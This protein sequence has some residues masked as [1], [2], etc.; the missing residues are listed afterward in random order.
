MLQLGPHNS[1]IRFRG[2]IKVMRGAYYSEFR[3]E[4]KRMAQMRVE[5][6]KKHKLANF[7]RQRSPLNES[8][9]LEFREYRD[10]QR[11]RMFFGRSYEYSQ[12]V[13]SKGGRK[14]VDVR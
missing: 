9:D 5:Y 12:D 10:I 2:E 13:S 1:E 11:K 7:E 4:N 8:F 14:P 6:R 3:K